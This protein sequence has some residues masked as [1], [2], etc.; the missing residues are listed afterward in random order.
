M[1]TQHVDITGESSSTS[2]SASTSTPDFPVTFIATSTDLSN[3]EIS[4][5]SDERLIFVL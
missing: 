2:F 3:E 1:M 4:F 5:V